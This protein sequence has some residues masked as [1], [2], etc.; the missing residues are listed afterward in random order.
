MKPPTAYRVGFQVA[1]GGAGDC[2]TI[3]Y[4]SKT[5][6]V[7]EVW[8]S[9]PSNA[10]TV[11]MNLHSALDSGGTATNPVG[12][13]LD[14]QDATATAVVS[15]YTA[16]PTAGTSLGTIAMLPMATTDTWVQDF[17][18]LN[19][20]ALA[21]QAAGQGLAIYVSGA[22]TITVNLEWSE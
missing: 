18:A 17:G 10:I 2:V 22:A 20:K 15:A 14:S 19:D 9:K 13:P 7:R 6:R 3:Y 5:V 21:L 8:I 4:A 16:A 11:S 1:C 12:V